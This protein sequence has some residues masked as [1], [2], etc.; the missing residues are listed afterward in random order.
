MVG[1]HGGNVSRVMRLAAEAR[2]AHPATRPDHE[3]N[4]DDHN[5]SVS[6]LDRTIKVNG[7]GLRENGITVP[8]DI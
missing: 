4:S 3:Y 5:L 8:R 2:P 6:R 7:L 1:L